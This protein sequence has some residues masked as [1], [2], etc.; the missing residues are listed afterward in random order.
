MINKY[1]RGWNI[2][3]ERGRRGRAIGINQNYCMNGE[4]QCNYVYIVYIR[5]ACERQ[6]LWTIAGATR[7]HMISFG[8]ISHTLRMRRN[9]LMNSPNT[10]T[11]T[12]YRWL[13][14]YQLPYS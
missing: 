10:C 9:A 8:L 7:A 12:N 1:T 6:L 4:R 13:P 14:G 11:Y 2:W 5:I 3:R